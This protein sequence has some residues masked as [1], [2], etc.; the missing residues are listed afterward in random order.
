MTDTLS[1]LRTL[2]EHGGSA[3]NRQLGCVI[4][5][6]EDRVRQ[7]CSRN[8]LVRFDRSFKPAR[9]I[10]TNAGLARM[11]ELEREKG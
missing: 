5:R 2:Y 6:K 11:T 8:G 9:W 3:T 7:W 4:D 10:V 1:F